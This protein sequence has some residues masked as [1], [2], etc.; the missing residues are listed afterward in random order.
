M[1]RKRKLCTQ[2]TPVAWCLSFTAL[3]DF[4]LLSRPLSGAEAFVAQKAAR[5]CSRSELE[6]VSRLNGA[7]RPSNVIV[8]GPIIFPST[9]AKGEKLSTASRSP[10]TPEELSLE[11]MVTDEPFFSF[12]PPISTDS[13]LKEM[14]MSQMIAMNVVG[15]AFTVGV[16]YSLAS[17]N[18]NSVFTGAATVEDISTVGIN[19]MDAALPLSATDVV[20]VTFS[21]AVA[22]V[23]AAV[24]SLSYSILLRLS[25]RKEQNR[26]QWQKDDIQKAVNNGDFFLAQAAALPLLE[27]LGLPSALATT[28]GVLLAAIPAEIVKV[29]SRK[30]REKREAEDYL[31]E[32][33]LKEEQER[34]QKE[35][36]FS[37]FQGK[38]QI[39]APVQT[40]AAWEKAIEDSKRN[41]DESLIV[42]VVSD[43]I[44]WL[45]YSVL[46]ADF[47]GQLTY[48]G[49]PLFPGVESA[50]FGVIATLSAQVYADILY[51]YFGFG[52]QEKSDEV[53]SRSLLSWASTYIT[54]AV[55][56]AIFFGVY[57]F[58]QIPAKA[59]V[60]AFLSGGAEACYG[61]QDFDVCL[62]AFESQ[63]P[64]GASPEAQFRSLVTTIAS[65]WNRYAPDSLAWTG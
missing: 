23:I 51:S 31:L 60:S 9:N 48:N 33:L 62:Q 61:S 34:K 64:P 41:R 57:E 42:D 54:E 53:R 5:S 46:C 63:N 6:G 21:E 25:T 50:I 32:L 12:F 36:M 19:I 39:S 52:G 29:A 3:L 13:R 40:M 1:L 43:I 38:P 37:F 18:L 27:G 4:A 55:Y 47:E 58:A 44:K 59:S 7:V 16:L 45:G 26:Y 11:Q 2:L 24:V 30:S 49:L 22:A 8:S 28:V 56:A 20:T 14:S 15:G 17:T 65:I 10:P 35:S